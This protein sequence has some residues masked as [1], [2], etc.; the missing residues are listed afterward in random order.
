VALLKGLADR[1]EVPADV[2]ESAQLLDAY[3]ITARYPNGWLA[4]A[5]KDYLNIK[6]G[7]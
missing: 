1:V 7:R 2:L 5:P 3:Y 4:G 6:R